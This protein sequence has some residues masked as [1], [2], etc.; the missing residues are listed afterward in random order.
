MEQ[1]SRLGITQHPQSWIFKSKLT[2]MMPLF[3]HSIVK[4]GSTAFIGGT[5]K[6]IL[7]LAEIRTLDILLKTNQFK[8]SLQLGM[9]G[10][11]LFGGY[12]LQLLW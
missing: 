5:G 2:A 10:Q 8:I 3:K 4:A 7:M 11:Q 12:G 1:T 6:Q 9:K